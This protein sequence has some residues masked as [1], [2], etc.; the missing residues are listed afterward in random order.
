MRCLW[1][2]ACRA[3][4]RSP[5]FSRETSD[6][7]ISRGP[8]RGIG[9]AKGEGAFGAQKGDNITHNSNDVPECPARNI[10]GAAVLQHG[11][12][13]FHCRISMSGC[14]RTRGRG[15]F[16]AQ[17]GK[18]RCELRMRRTWTIPHGPALRVRSSSQTRNVLGSADGPQKQGIRRVLL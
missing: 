10:G 5:P 7:S 16:R 15:C 12:R 13:E 9:E 17:E 18:Q 3:T 14:Y 1:D 4:L 6:L 2:S 8:D 11:P